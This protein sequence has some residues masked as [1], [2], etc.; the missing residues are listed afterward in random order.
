[1]LQKIKTIKKNYI[2]KKL[3]FLFALLTS[4]AASA[5]VTVTP[6][7]IDYNA[8][9]VTFSVAWNSAAYNN[10]VW[11]WIDLC[12]IAGTLPSG[13]F[14]PADVANP[15]ITGGNGTITNPT[16]R[17]FFITYAGTNSGTTVTAMLSNAPAGKF[18][19]CV[20]GSDAP[21]EAEVLPDGGYKLHGTPPFTVNGTKLDDGVKTFGA[22]TCITSITDLTGN[23][24]GNPHAIPQATISGAATNPCPATT[25][26]L[27]AAAA[28]AATFT[29]YKNGAQVQ[30]GTSTSY[31]VTATG[32]YTV[33]GIHANC[34]G[35]ASTDKSVTI[36]NCTGCV[37]ST[38]TLT[39]V[40]FSSSANYTRNG[41]IMSSPVTVTTCQKTDYDGGSNGSYIAD[42]RSS[43]DFAGHIFSWC[44]VSQYAAVLCPSPWRVPTKADICKILN[45]STDNCE[46]NLSLRLD[47]VGLINT[48]YINNFEYYYV[49]TG[50]YRRSIWWS[51]TD[52]SDIGQTDA[53]TLT[54][55]PTGSLLNSGYKNSGYAVKCVR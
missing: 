15:A 53:Y 30:S 18:N 39:G 44:L 47:N 8:R 5:T 21:P 35:T 52:R 11:V 13:A 41:L 49:S 50:S 23:P 38:L 26:V 55:D 36:S 46:I 54:A 6:L 4:I 22:G 9:K 31:T 10:R 19:W 7:S 20:Y 3:F 48:A 37:A 16:T 1:M 27:T 25:A 28:N 45:N 40:G 24:D 17:G 34:T 43:P 51:Q 42:C 32:S 29:W 12:P 33:R 14:T 2:M